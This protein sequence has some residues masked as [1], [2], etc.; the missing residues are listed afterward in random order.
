MEAESVSGAALP[1]EALPAPAGD[2]FYVIEE[3]SFTVFNEA[4]Q[5]LARI[6]K[7]SCFGELAL[8]RQAC[9]TRQ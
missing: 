2:M 4:Q 8:L 5:E 3:G 6:T 9:P 7:G 1:A